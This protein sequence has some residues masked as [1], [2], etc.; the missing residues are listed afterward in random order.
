MIAEN[1]G[2]RVL[3]C[4][5]QI[6]LELFE[7]SSATSGELSSRCH[8]ALATFQKSL[9]NLAARQLIG[10]ERDD[11][12]GRRRTW[13]LS[14]DTH[15]IL[16]QEL[17]FPVM[18]EPCG[19]R[20]DAEKGIFGSVTRLQDLLRTKVF[21]GEFQILLWL[22][23]E[24]CL[25]TGELLARSDTSPGAFYMALKRLADLRLIDD[26]PDHADR[27]RKL[28]RLTGKTRAALDEFYIGLREWANNLPPP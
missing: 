23:D 7:N 24:E 9:G 19:R 25:T 15:D 18:W 28:H 20:A 14:T 2:I 26:L 27:R 21:S 13:R 16:T 11:A 8:V 4:E 12:D 5:Y 17:R 1:L 6:L 22:Y 3:S 10:W